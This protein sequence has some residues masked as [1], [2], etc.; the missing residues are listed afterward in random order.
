MCPSCWWERTPRRTDSSLKHSGTITEPNKDRH[1]DQNSITFKEKRMFAGESQ[2]TF[3]FLI[4]SCW[5]E[6]LKISDSRW[7]Q[8]MPLTRHRESGVCQSTHFLYTPSVSSAL[9]IHKENEHLS[10][11]IKRQNERPV[12]SASHWTSV[13]W[14]KHLQLRLNSTNI[15]CSH[16]NA[17]FLSYGAGYICL[18]KIGQSFVRTDRGFKTL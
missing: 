2:R 3:Q 15:W 10:T 18:Q 9:W 17:C 1:T 5:S 14:R 16:F 4:A 8:V 7:W 6:R 11:R 13:K 12:S